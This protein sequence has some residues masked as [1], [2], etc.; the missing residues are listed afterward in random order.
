MGA[1]ALS[2]SQTVHPK[3]TLMNA[4]V[5]PIVQVRLSRLAQA[6]NTA[7]VEIEYAGKTMLGWAKEAGD[8]LIEAKQECAHGEFKAWVEANC[9]VSYRQAAN[10]MKVA[11]EWD[12]R[13]D[14]VGCTFSDLSIDAFLGYEKKPKPIITPS[15]N[16]PTFDRHDAEYVLKIAGMRRSDFVGEATAAQVKLDKYADKTLL[17]HAKQAGKALKDRRG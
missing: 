9:T 4:V 16:L 15:N 12:Q 8:A 3:G 13:K 6:I 11:R 2:I 7:Q 17:L 14:A 5:Y 1:C 10:Y